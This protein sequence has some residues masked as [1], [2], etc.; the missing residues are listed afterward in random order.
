MFYVRY[1]PVKAPLCRDP[2][3]WIML[4]DATILGAMF[5]SELLEVPH[6]FVFLFHLPQAVT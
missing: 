5:A 6:Y 3:A 1:V 4:L 2:K